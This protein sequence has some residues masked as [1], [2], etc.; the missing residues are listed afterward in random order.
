MWIMF[1]IVMGN[2]ASG[3]YDSTISVT[4]S[5]FSSKEACINAVNFSKKRQK[6][7]DAWCVKK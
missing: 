3:H 5:E 7:Q 6:V 4:Q 1:L 2:P